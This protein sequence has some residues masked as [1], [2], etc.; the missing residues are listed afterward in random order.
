MVMTD[1]CEIYE[2]L[3]GSGFKALKFIVY[4]NR[5]WGSI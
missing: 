4:F 5:C 2:C 3:I 1:L